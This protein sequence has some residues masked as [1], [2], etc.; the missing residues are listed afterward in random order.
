MFVHDE[1]TNTVKLREGKSPPWLRD[2]SKMKQTD[3]KMWL[4]CPECK[5]RY[6]PDGGKRNQSHIPYRDK[7]SQFNLRPHHRGCDDVAEESG[8]QPEPEAEVPPG[9]EDDAA[10]EESDGEPNLPLRGEDPVPELPQPAAMPELA[11]YKAAWAERK[12]YHSQGN[13]Q[14]FSMQNLVPKPVSQLGQDCHRLT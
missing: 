11:T 1:A 5:D 6:C 8:T 4:F 13:A 14:D 12:A 7:A 3:R 9:E 2:F 10:V